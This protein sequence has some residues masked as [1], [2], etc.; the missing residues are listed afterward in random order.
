MDSANRGPRACR[1]GLR[2]PGRPSWLVLRSSTLNDPQRW[3]RESVAAKGAENGGV[4]PSES[5]EETV[6]FILEAEATSDMVDELKDDAIAKLPNALRASLTL[7]PA[8]L[9]PAAG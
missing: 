7:Q 1:R 2:R 3:A 8:L 4:E 9:G 5:I 6:D